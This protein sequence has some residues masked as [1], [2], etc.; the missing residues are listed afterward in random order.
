MVK[1]SSEQLSAGLLPDCVSISVDLPL[2]IATNP[3]ETTQEESL[4]EFTVEGF[5]ERQESSGP[6]CPV[7]VGRS[8][9]PVVEEPGPAQAWV[10]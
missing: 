2:H 9:G 6:L 1:A 3:F 5:A 10:S 7:R 4:S 8:S